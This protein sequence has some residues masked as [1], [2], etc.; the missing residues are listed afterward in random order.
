MKL[1]Q[2]K[3]WIEE[4]EKAYEEDIIIELF[5]TTTKESYDIDNLIYSFSDKVL[6]FEFEN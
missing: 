2:L 3:Q 5:G 4:A 1:K 6:Q